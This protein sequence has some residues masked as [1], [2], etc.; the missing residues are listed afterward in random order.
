MPELQDRIAVITGSGHGLGRMIAVEL[1]G[2]GARVVVAARSEAESRSLPGTI[3][4]TAE[5]IKTAGGYALPVRR[6]GLGR[7]V[8]PL[9]R[10]GVNAPNG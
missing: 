3:Y 4:R 8:P 2:R 9:A 5:T 10:P 1:A 7:R 6:G